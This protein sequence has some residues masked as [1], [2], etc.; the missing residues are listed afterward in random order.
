[1][2]VAFYAPLK[3]PDHP[4]PSGDRRMAALLMRALRQGGH[5]VELAA[6]LRGRDPGGDPA[7][8]AR[9]RAVGAHLAK[10]LVRRYRARPLSARPAVWFTYHLYYKAPDWIGPAVAGALEIPYLVAEASHAPKRAD[11][12]W[13]LGH[14]AT[15]DAIRRAAAIIGL[16]PHDSDCLRP[17][18]AP[19]A[20][21]VALKPFLDPGP[22]RVARAA[23]AR[24]RA[25]IG[26]AHGLPPDMPWLLA[27]A[28]M[29][30][31][32]KLASYRLLAQ[33]LAAV[34][35]RPWR[36][37]ILGDGPARA[38]VEAAFAKLGARVV[39]AGAQPPER[40]AA[41]YAAA[42][43]MVWPAINEAYGMALLEAQ[44]S[45]L[46]V[47]AGATGGVP[48][49]VA[50][51]VTGCLAP[52]G[53]APAFADAVAALLDAPERRADMSAAALQKT[54]R[55]HGLDGAAAIL[56]TVLHQAIAERAA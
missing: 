55:E 49:I 32:D 12:P 36:L 3:P 51:D 43:L 24:H 40:L 20:R 10:R 45:G 6:R 50:E 23:R 19:P 26:A 8:Q 21:L 4:V 41:F 35:D 13:R 44:A 33:A 31:G 11:G 39:F 37:V 30:G 28:M 9:L 38:R 18:I 27:V 47:V 54:V 34:E 7:R 29:R 56:D 42:D 15:E 2:R 17:L 25:D 16:N 1:M 48:A 52:V 53:D 5:D 46:P 22:Y 14:A